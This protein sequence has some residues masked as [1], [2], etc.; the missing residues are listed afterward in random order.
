[1]YF[2]FLFLVKSSVKSCFNVE[3]EMSYDSGVGGSSRN[4]WAVQ[5][6]RLIE[7][8]NKQP[9]CNHSNIVFQDVR[10]TS[11]RDFHIRP[12]IVFRYSGTNANASNIYQQFQECIKVI[13]T[14]QASVKSFMDGFD[15][16][17]VTYAPKSV[18][19]RSNISCCG[20][21]IGV[22]CEG[23]NQVKVLGETMAASYCCKYMKIFWEPDESEKYARR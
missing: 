18:T 3:L 7:Y 5:S 23:N 11:S 15:V 9:Q 2:L 19:V 6:L 4:D 14:Q 8:F 17:G 12:K 22:C 10:G 1:M 16:S 21:N 13:S 20:G